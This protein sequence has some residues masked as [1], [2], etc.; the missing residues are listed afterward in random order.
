MANRDVAAFGGLTLWDPR[1]A[2]TSVGSRERLHAEPASCARPSLRR[3][4]RGGWGVQQAATSATWSSSSSAA[5]ATG[6][7]D[8]RPS[9]RM[10]GRAAR[11]NS[12]ANA[13]PNAP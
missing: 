13:R 2:E 8:P 4:L 12:A 11:A 10:W 9:E 6:G 5:C 3:A 7:A 1:G